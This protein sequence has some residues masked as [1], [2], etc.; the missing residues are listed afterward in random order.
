MHGLRL[1]SRSRC[2]VALWCVDETRGPP[3]S[4]AP[5]SLIVAGRVE[6][7]GAKGA[8]LAARVGRCA[9]WAWHGARR[10][11]STHLLPLLSG[12]AAA[13]QTDDV[14]LL[15]LG[16]CELFQALLVM[17]Y[18]LGLPAQEG[19]ST[20]G[21]AHVAAGGLRLQSSLQPLRSTPRFDADLPAFRCT[22]RHAARGP[23]SGAC[24]KK[25]NHA[26]RMR[27][28]RAAHRHAHDLA[29]AVVLLL[30]QRL[31]RRDEHDLALG[32]RNGERLGRCPCLEAREIGRMTCRRGVGARHPRPGR[33]LPPCLNTPPQ[34]IAKRRRPPLGTSGRS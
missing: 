1:A 32:G 30:H 13:L 33:A 15:G 6:W 10:F 25:Q 26:T 21:R 12:A 17:P 34:R 20:G 24:R 9:V 7:R 5:R 28:P 29:A 19:A 4:F 11:L 16:R 18:S 8:R 22:R 14:R 2:T 3:P 27:D 31:G 23:A